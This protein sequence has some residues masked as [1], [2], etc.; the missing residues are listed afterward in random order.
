MTSSVDSMFKR[1]ETDSCPDP[2][3]SANTRIAG[4]AGFAMGYPTVL[5]NKNDSPLYPLGV[6]PIPPPLTMPHFWQYP[7]YRTFASRAGSDACIKL[8][9]VFSSLPQNASK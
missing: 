8:E 6:R 5:T 7:E 2:P 1:V 3:R 4:T 9:E